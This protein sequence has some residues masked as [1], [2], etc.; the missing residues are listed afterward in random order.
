MRGVVMSATTVGSAEVSVRGRPAE[1]GRFKALS[2]MLTGVTL[3]VVVAGLRD[4]ELAGLGWAPLIWLGL[5]V[6]A[7]F[8]VVP[9]GDSASLSMDL[10]LLLG[11]AVVFPPAVC[12]LIALIG[13]SD[14]R[15]WRRRVTG[16]LA[17]YNRSQVA[18]SVVAASVTFHT[19]GGRIS[20]WPWGAIASLIALSVDC[21]V[22]YSF[23]ALAVSLR[24]SSTFRR[25]LATLR[26][27]EP[28]VF[29]PTY[30]SFGFLGA[31]LGETYAS[32]GLIG[33]VAFVAPMLLARQVFSHWRE[34]ERFARSLSVRTRALEDVD[35]RI[36]EERRDE[37]LVLAGD[38]HDEVLPP[39]FKVH[40]MGEV[41]KRDLESGRLLDLDDDLPQL[42]HAT[43]TAQD[44]I[45]KV[46]RN[47]RAS[48]VGPEG[49]NSTLRLLAKTVETET[50][51]KIHLD[52]D[53]VRGSSANQFL[54]YQIAREGLYN[55]AKHSRASLIQMTLASEG[56]TARLSVADD[57]IG[58]E[59]ATVDT[60]FHFGLQLLAERVEAAGGIL[61]V[62]S[63]L[64]VGT[65]IVASI[66]TDGA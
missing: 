62:V 65:T 19:L 12:G 60:E 1:T 2:L 32:V 55:A 46:L 11:A 5:V 38:I 31:L 3:V 37:R 17:V 21:L 23:V 45:R 54:L 35:R 16:W 13:A 43:A 49:L 10:P 28:R 64:G 36:L 4:L 7:S 47:L 42:L 20:V 48:S 59:P 22:N 56:S 34:L 27:G 53:D 26:F 44:A 14:P 18:L 8:V 30:V 66:P 33:V 41:L 25:S 24:Q 50:D 63:E 52:L 58:F 57:G 29:I 15:E 6:C 9:T 39:L 61:H 51:A 40:L